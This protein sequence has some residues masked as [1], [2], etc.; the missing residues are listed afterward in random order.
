[1]GFYTVPM[2]QRSAKLAAWIAF[3]YRI[4]LDRAHILSHANLPAPFQSLTSSMHWDP[5]PFW[6]WPYYFQLVRRQYRELAKKTALPTPQVPKRFRRGPRSGRST[7][8]GPP[9]RP[10]T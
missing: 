2:Y 10:P 8:A 6:D 4:P 1:M 3:T 7:S 5:G 9:P